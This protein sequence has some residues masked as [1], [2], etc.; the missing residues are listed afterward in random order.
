MLFSCVGQREIKYEE[1]DIGSFF[2]DLMESLDLPHDVEVKLGDNLPVIGTEPTLL[3]QIFQNLIENGIKFN[4]SPQKLIEIQ[5]RSSDDD[6]YDLSVHDNGIGIEP[7]HREKIFGVF[8]RLHTEEEYKGTGIGLAIVKK[9]VSR[10]GGGIRMESKAGE[11]STFII[12][13]PKHYKEAVS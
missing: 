5:G 7:R 2:R 4:D 9:A 1:I 3:R 13:L 10:L 11:G 8:Q 12:T 6:Y